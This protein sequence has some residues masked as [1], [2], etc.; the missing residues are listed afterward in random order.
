MPDLSTWIGR[1]DRNLLLVALQTGLRVSEL[2]GLNVGDVV[3]GPSRQPHVRCRG[4]GRKD[5]ETPLRG[6]STKALAEWLPGEGRRGA[7]TVVREQPQ[8]ALQS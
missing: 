8:R 5:R 1:R 2:I 7:G 4:K 6:D 3:L